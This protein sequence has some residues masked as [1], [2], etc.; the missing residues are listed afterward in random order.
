MFR[1]HLSA[2]A[3]LLVS[4][5]ILPLIAGDEMSMPS[6]P[7]PAPVEAAPSSSVSGSLSLDV[8]THFISYGADIWGGGNDFDDALFNPSLELAWDLGNDL[9]FTLGTWWDINDKAVSSIGK[10]VQEVDVWAGISYGG[11]PVEVS[12]T[13]QEWMYAEESERIVDLGLGFDAPLSPSL[14]IHGRVDDGASGGDLGVVAVAGIELP[15]F[16]LGTVEF[17]LPV[18]VAFATDGFH[19]GDAGFA[20]ASAGVGASIPLAF[21]SDALGSWALNAGV[22]YYYTNSD[23]IPNNPDESFLTGTVGIGLSF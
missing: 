21:M 14:T 1:H 18:S 3:L 13:Y 4:G 20:F 6:A 16:T 22:T 2:G 17:S 7:A 5:C 19:G 12:L 23:V 15:S 10:N 9:T 11:G 8:N